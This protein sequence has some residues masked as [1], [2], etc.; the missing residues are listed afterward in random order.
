M[1]YIRLIDEH[2]AEGLLATAFRQARERAGKVYQI[3]RCMSLAPR[4][5]VASL[6]LY[7]EVMHGA[8]PLSRAQR[9]MIAVAVSSANACHY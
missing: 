9:E 4:Q 2:E 5:L 1:A 3:V 8:S 7:R 6:G